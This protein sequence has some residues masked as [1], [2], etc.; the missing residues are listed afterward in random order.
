MRGWTYRCERSSEALTAA[1][2]RVEEAAAIAKKMMTV[3]NKG[4]AVGDPEQN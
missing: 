3:R 2:A 4:N 1:G